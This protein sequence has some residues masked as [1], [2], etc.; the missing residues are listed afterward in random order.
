MVTNT[1]RYEYNEVT[2]ITTPTSN[3]HSPRLPIQTSWDFN[4]K[5]TSMTLHQE[6]GNEFKTFDALWVKEDVEGKSKE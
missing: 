4:A 6:I 3:F 1:Y 2:G 5:F